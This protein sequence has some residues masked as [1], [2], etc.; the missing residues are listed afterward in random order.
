MDFPDEGV[1][2]LGGPQ[3]AGQLD[4]IATRFARLD[5]AAR[6]GRAL[7]DGLAVVIAGPPNAGKSSLLNALAGHDAA[8]V[9]EVPG[10]T[11]DLLRE[12]IV[13]DGLPV[14][15]VDT[16]GLRHTADLIEGEGV[17]R[18]RAEI[19]R[20]DLVLYV[21]DATT[22]PQPEAIESDLAALHS[23][24]AV[25]KVWNKID[26][27][28]EP[29]PG[30]DRDVARSGSDPATAVYI[31]A[32]TGAGLDA[33]RTHLRRVAGYHAGEG[34]AFSARRRHL[35]ALGRARAHAEAARTRL[36]A[37]ESY[38]L[39]AEELRLAHQALGDIT[40]ETTSDDLL[41]E[42]FAGFCIGK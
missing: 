1:D 41:G 2:W 23:R 13:V 19:S 42:I 26:L 31:S 36:E 40:G 17:R 20:A 32:K 3:V 29:V 25:L 38:E 14:H 27:Q 10:T 6:Q 5:G 37:R 28:E 16:A 12:Q 35:D 18:A 8:I 11:R 9:T 7:R 4:E 33:L 34:G 24:A 30:M 22:P 39:A 21:M 15:V